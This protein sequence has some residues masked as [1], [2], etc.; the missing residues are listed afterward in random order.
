MSI[1][2]ITNSKAELLDPD[3]LKD[4]VERLANDGVG[5]LLVGQND[6]LGGT[7]TD[8]DL[9][10]RGIGKD[11]GVTSAGDILT[12][13]V[14]YCRDDQDAEDVARDKSKQQLRRMPVTNPDERLVGVVSICEM[15]QYL[16]P[17][18]VGQVLQGATSDK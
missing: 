3:S 13:P 12:E 11:P 5:S 9:V 4:A 7:V 6:E 14:L 16:S 10:V 17:D 15:A 2:G 8:R 1:K 18:G